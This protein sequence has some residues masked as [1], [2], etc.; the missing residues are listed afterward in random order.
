MLCKSCKTNPTANE[1]HDHRCRQCIRDAHKRW[2]DAHPGKNK[3][4]YLLAKKRQ[5][6]ARRHYRRMAGNAK[7]R[8]K[9]G[10]LPCEITTEFLL[11]LHEQ[12]HGR[13]ALTGRLFTFISRNQRE[14]AF[15]NSSLDRV[16]PSKG[17]TVNNVR[18]ITHWANVMKYSASDDELFEMCR[19]ILAHSEI[20]LSFKLTVP[21]K[22]L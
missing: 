4:Y 21:Q 16:E 10:R 11:A 7:M 12:Q 1:S 14:A 18:L 5:P 9:A 19:A 13:C 8:A 3:E 6:T 22:V 20:N 15:D 17:Y 2:R